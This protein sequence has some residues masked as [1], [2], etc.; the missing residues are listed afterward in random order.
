MTS[1]D[2]ELLLSPR[3]GPYFLKFFHPG[4]IKPVLLSWRCFPGLW[5]VGSGRVPRL[6][7]LLLRHELVRQKGVVLKIL[8]CVCFGF[9]ACPFII[10]LKSYFTYSFALCVYSF[11]I[12]YPFFGYPGAIYHCFIAFPPFSF[13][14][15]LLLISS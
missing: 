9:N 13:Q 6:Y 8:L 14:F 7:P 4:I 1:T 15:S 10:T 11:S 3:E 2:N 5:A 12:I